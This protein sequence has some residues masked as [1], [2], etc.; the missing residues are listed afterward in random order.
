[1]KPADPLTADLE[2]KTQAF[3]TLVEEERSPIKSSLSDVPTLKNAYSDLRNIARALDQYARINRSL[4]Y[5]GLM[6]TFS[7]GKSSVINS[8]IGKDVRAADL[9]PIDD[10]ITILTHPTNRDA[11]LGAHSRGLLKVTTQPVDAD[12][13]LNCFLV[14]TP[15]S[16]DPEIREGMVKDFL[17]IC[18]LILYTFSA[19]SALSI[20]DLSILTTIQDQLDFVPI[21][22]VISRSDEFRRDR[23]ALLSKDNVDQSRLDQFLANL[24]GR[25]RTQAPRLDLSPGHFFFVDNHTKF[26]ID[27]L[28]SHILLELESDVQLHS[29]KIAYFRREVAAQKAVFESYLSTLIE[30]VSQLEYKAKLNKENYENNVVLSFQSINDFWRPREGAQTT[31]I[32]AFAKMRDAWDSNQSK[33]LPDFGARWTSSPNLHQLIEQKS[34]EFSQDLRRQLLTTGSTE[35]LRLKETYDVKLADLIKEGGKIVAPSLPPTYRTQIADILAP[36][37]Y[38]SLKSALE[39]TRNDLLNDLR[40]SLQVDRVEFESLFEHAKRSDLSNKDNEYYRDFEAVIRNN[41]REFL[42]IVTLFKSAVTSTQARNL[43]SRT[44]LGERLDVLDNVDVDVLAANYQ[45]DLFL[46]KVF[47]TRRARHDVLSRSTS[48]LLERKDLVESKLN[49]VRV[50]IM[51]EGRAASDL[52]ELST[53][54]VEADQFLHPLADRLITILEKEISSVC[55]IWNQALEQLHHSFVADVD[56]NRSQLFRGWIQRFSGIFGIATFL[57]AIA[58]G[59]LFATGLQN[60]IGWAWTIISGALTTATVSVL[61][62]GWRKLSISEAVFPKTRFR[63]AKEIIEKT[64]PRLEPTSI[65][66]STDLDHAVS[67]AKEEFTSALLGFLTKDRDRHLSRYGSIAE[68]ERTLIADESKFVTSYLRDWNDLA[69]GVNDWYHPDE[70]KKNLISEA[71][72]AIKQRAIEPALR[73]F[74]ERLTEVRNFSERLQ[75]LS[76]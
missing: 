15:G 64:V 14:D 45:A 17:P 11:L 51:E 60:Q 31:R 1:M 28:K 32:A 76:I 3:L 53:L 2:N 49:E 47:A 4:R 20:P 13:L 35:L 56:T 65:E 10:E 29:K 22:F 54:E 75:A 59:G 6:G 7:S 74:A 63:I 61:A 33:Q 27:E 21:R 44:G 40:D 19:T 41:L 39:L 71:A 34:S 37:V 25:I 68:E 18:D 62:W 57:G 24:I 43:I 42:P 9:P 73:L 52:V 66:Q 23:Q 36:S 30:D 50:R 72:V 58:V 55:D 26:G 5:I 48:A 70:F 12:L 46:E 67:A 16:G 38:R 69:N 8:L